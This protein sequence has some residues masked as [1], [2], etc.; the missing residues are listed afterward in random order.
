MDLSRLQELGGF[1]PPTPVKREVTW[2]PENGEPVTFAVHIKKLS[3]GH[4]ERL[5][6]DPRRER[7]VSALMVSE[8]LLLGDDANETIPFDR[9]FELDRSLADVLLEA[10][11]DVNPVTKRKVASAKN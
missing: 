2:A 3:A 9:A 5:F 6:R 11:E 8:T 4:V 10:I 7:S 1:V